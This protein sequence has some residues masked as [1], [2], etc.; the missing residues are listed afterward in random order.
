MAAVQSTPHGENILEV[1]SRRDGRIRTL[2]QLLK[3]CQVDLKV[4]EVERY[5]VNKWEVGAKDPDGEIVVTPLFQVKATL[6]RKVM[7]AG[8][9]I[10]RPIDTPKRYQTYTKPPGRRKAVHTAL[11]LPDPQFGFRRTADGVLHPFHDWRALD[12]AIQ[13]AYEVKPSY[14]ICLGDMLDLPEWS[15]KFPR[16][17]E[18]QQTT[19]SAIVAAHWWLRRLREAR[20]G[21]AIWLLEGNH[22]KRLELALVN[23]LKAA[24]GLRPADELELPPSM[25]IPRLLALH[26]LGIH[27]SDA[28]PDGEHWLTDRLLCIHGNV[29]R[30]RS[31]ATVQAALKDY[32]VSVI[33]GHIHRM[34][35]AL[36]TKYDRKGAYTIG[37][38]SPGCL[39]R[40][41]G[42]VPGRKKR[43]NWQQGVAVV[44]FEGREQHV[45]LVEI[46]DGKAL[47]GGKLFEGKDRSEMVQLDTGWS[48]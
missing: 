5:T 29:T 17:P 34:E 4:W 12:V 35:M 16:T 22:D 7:K 47:F 20:P 30:N 25:S 23:H 32:D 40:V 2:D 10:V 14:I 39:C 31:G 27:Y 11:I 15:D 6:R 28:Y 44:Q 21:A 36:R 8:Q 19:Q 3:A 41:D 48:L 9:P 46:R 38:Y 45:E 1:E 18:F 24:Y 42:A 13:M 37:A 43:Q 33:F 26:R